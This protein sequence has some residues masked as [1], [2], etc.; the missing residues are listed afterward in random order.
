[1]ASTRVSVEI[2]VPRSCGSRHRFVATLTYPGRSK[3]KAT[4]PVGMPLP[5]AVALLV[6]P[7]DE[8][9]LAFRPDR[10]ASAWRASDRIDLSEVLPDFELTVE[11]LFASLRH[12]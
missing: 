5:G 2:R 7:A 10:Q 12:S 11:Q 9:V 1:M 4:L 8:S 6:D 3:K